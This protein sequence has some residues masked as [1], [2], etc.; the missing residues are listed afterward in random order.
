MM[1]AHLLSR[2]DKLPSVSSLL[3]VLTHSASA[4][5]IARIQTHFIVHT[6]TKLNVF[7]TQAAPSPCTST[8]SGF[9]LLSIFYFYFLFQVSELVVP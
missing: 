7:Q 5:S 8:F 2:Q 1:N 9:L 4:D 6:H 3:S